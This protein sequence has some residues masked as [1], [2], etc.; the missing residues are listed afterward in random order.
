MRKPSLTRTLHRLPQ[1]TFY[2]LK[3]G[4]EDNKMLFMEV[5]CKCV[6]LYANVL[7]LVLEVA[8]FVE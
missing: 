5:L 2:H 4:L 3:N 1:S 7:I 6:N 8:V